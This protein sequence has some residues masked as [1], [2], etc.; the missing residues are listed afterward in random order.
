[1]IKYE[2]LH[3]VFDHVQQQKGRSPVTGSTKMLLRLASLAGKNDNYLVSSTFG[4]DKDKQRLH[5]LRG[6]W[7]H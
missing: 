6:K 3:H 4:V 2:S 7:F 5:E 1:M